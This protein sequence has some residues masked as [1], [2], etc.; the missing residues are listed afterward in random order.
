[1]TSGVISLNVA[2]LFLFSYFFKDFIYLFDREGEAVG[3]E[4]ERE[5]HASR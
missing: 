2:F 4:K 1:M 5:K 3:E